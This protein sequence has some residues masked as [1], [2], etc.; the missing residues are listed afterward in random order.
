MS[1]S[2]NSKS[3][4]FSLLFFPERNPEIKKNLDEIAKNREE[5]NRS[6]DRLEELTGKDFSDLKFKKPNN[7][8]TF[9][10]SFGCFLIIAM[11][12]AFAI[13]I[14]WAIFIH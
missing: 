1:D 6:C 4:L 3:S 9:T 2:D 7:R 5:F 8:M 12:A 11:F 14:A 10:E 13:W